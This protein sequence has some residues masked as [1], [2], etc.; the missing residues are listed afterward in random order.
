MKNKKN[1]FEKNL[2]SIRLAEF[3]RS[4]ASGVEGNSGDTKGS[5][6]FDLSGL[7]AVKMEIKRKKGGTFGL[8]LKME[9]TAGRNQGEQSAKE[10][11]QKKEETA[12][13]ETKASVTQHTAEDATGASTE[14]SK[15]DA[16]EKL[17]K[18]EIDELNCSGCEDCVDSL[19]N[20]FEMSD[21]GELARVKMTQIPA[22]IEDDI[23][24]AADDCPADA[25][26]VE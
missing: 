26:S 20:V 12:A 24:E 16:A 21:D 14:E 13:S 10:E 17:L 4:L 3:L 8:K 11:R 9:I 2:D 15:S 23:R 25:I 6:G 22:E 7:D 18:V 5:F 1:K 19:P